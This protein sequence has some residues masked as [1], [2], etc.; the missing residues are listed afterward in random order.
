MNQ[1]QAAREIAD[2]L[3]KTEDCRAKVK[4]GKAGAV[5]VVCE[6]DSGGK[7]GWISAGEIVVAET[8]EVSK[9]TS[10]AFRYFKEELQAALAGVTYAFEAPTAPTE[11]ELKSQRL[12]EAARMFRAGKVVD[13]D[14]LVDCVSHGYLTQSEVMNRDF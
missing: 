9:E 4:F 3:N 13:D 5:I 10:F 11:G 6:R 12:A 1:T 7:K 2:R 14:I 8:I